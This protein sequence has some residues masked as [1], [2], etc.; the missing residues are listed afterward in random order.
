MFVKDD[1]ENREK[2]DDY[3]F[4]PIIPQ[5]VSL[6]KKK[7]T[8]RKQ[9]RSKIKIKLKTKKKLKIKI[10]FRKKREQNLKTNREPKRPL[11]N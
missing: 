9:N 6:H 2:M 10:K 1:S 4:P 8:C 5:N 3:F 7:L 11:K